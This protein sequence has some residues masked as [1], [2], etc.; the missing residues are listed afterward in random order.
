[1]FI[2]VT[3]I[4]DETLIFQ[5]DRILYM[6]RDAKGDTTDLL[7][8]LNHES[9]WLDVQETPEQIIALLEGKAETPAVPLIDYEQETL[10]RRAIIE[11]SQVQENLSESHGDPEYYEWTDYVLRLLRG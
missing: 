9:R 10:R 1:M 11:I 5:H 3:S 8:A 6:G 2:K 4:N 7:L